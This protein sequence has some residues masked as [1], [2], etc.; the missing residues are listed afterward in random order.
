MRNPI[1]QN[2]NNGI[3]DYYVTALYD[4]G[5]S[6]P[7]NSVEVMIDQPVIL[8][9]D[10]MALVD[11]YNQCGGMFWN[12][13]ENWL[14]GPVN[15]WYG[16]TTVEN[17]VTKVMLGVNGLFGAI[18]ESFGYLSAVDDLYLAGNN[19]ESLPESIGNLQACSE[20]WISSNSLTALPESIGDMVALEE[21]AS[22]QNCS[23]DQNQL[24]ELPENFGNLSILL[25]LSLSYNNLT[26]LPVSFGDLNAYE[27]LIVENQLEELPE[28][29]GKIDNIQFLGLDRNNLTT[30]PANFGELLTLGYLGI[31]E[32]QLES[33][34]ESFGDL[35]A[36]TLL[37]SSN[38]LAEIPEGLFDNLF[39]YLW[40]ADNHLQF[41][42]IEPFIGQ[43]SQELTY[44]PQAD[45]GTDTNL[46]LVVGDTLSYAY[47]VSGE[48]NEYQWYFNDQEIEGAYTSS[49]YIENITEDD[50]GVYKLVVTNTLVADLVLESEPMNVY[51]S[52]VNIPENG[53]EDLKVYPN[54]VTDGKVIVDFPEKEQFDHLE[55]LN[56]IS[57]DSIL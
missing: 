17:R 27:I 13:A 42:S 38:H 5:E 36:D 8:E 57:R 3:Y 37:L 25:E 40:L 18:P 29:F 28:T 44:I 22:L 31:T 47:D 16:I 15:E 45:F 1:D 24:I 35:E 53:T 46:F 32:N 23:L 26:H 51:I 6:D 12:N 43:V 41:G 9:A 48:N 39:I 56:T 50:E 10:S 49:I 19:I 11:L 14:N 7:S 20:F 30:L 21:L 2:L 54:P 33:L 4:E 55:I 52:L 34:P